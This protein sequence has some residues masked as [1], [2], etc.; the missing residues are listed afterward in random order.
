MVEKGRTIAQAIAA[1][2]YHQLTVYAPMANGGRRHVGTYDPPACESMDEVIDCFF[3]L[4]GP[5]GPDHT[6]EG[7]RI[8]GGS[9]GAY[10]LDNLIDVTECLRT[11]RSIFA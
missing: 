5:I 6:A 9:I 11:K 10:Q 1:G 2:N 8:V 7:A 3:A 4:F